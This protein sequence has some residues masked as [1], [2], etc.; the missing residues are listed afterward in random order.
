LISRRRAADGTS[1][2]AFVAIARAAVA[3]AVAGAVGC[4]TVDNGDPPADVNA[5]RPSQQ[6]FYDKVCPDFLA[7]DY[8]G[9]TCK[10]ANCHGP[11]SMGSALKITVTT[12]TPDPPPAIPF[13]SNSDWFA[14]YLST[15]QAMNCTDVTGAALYTKPSGL[16]PPHGGGTLF[17][18]G[19]PEF[20]L[21]QKW[22]MPG[23]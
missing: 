19:G 10:D 4:S 3:I 22:V 13:V 2:A 14:S 20:D 21:L 6:Y 23:P 18:P 15:A 8:A 12:C 17:A 16:K 1:A 5:C 7:M 11:T 9:K